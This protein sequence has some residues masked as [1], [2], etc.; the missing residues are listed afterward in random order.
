MN[1]KYRLKNTKN[2]DV[3]TQLFFISF[4]TKRVRQLRIIKQD[5]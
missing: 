3:K 5:A 1:I 4:E 2:I